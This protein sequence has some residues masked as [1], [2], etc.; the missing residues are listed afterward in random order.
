MST[1]SNSTAGLAGRVAIVTGA[2]RGIGRCHALFLAEHGAKVVVNDYG[3]SREG[4]G[5]DLSPA[6]S[7]VREIQAAGGEAVT[8]ADDVADW[9]GA[10]RLVDTAITAF[11]GLDIL[12][13]NA[14]FV[15]DRTLVNMSEGEWDDVIRVHLKG[16]FCPTRHAAAYWRDRSKAGQQPNAAVINTSSTSGLFGK[17]GQS[18]YGAAKMGL[19][20]FTMITAEELSRYGVRVNAIAPAARTRLTQGLGGAVDE[21]PAAGTFDELDPANVSPMV[22]YLASGDCSI[23]GKVFLV[24]GGQVHLFKPFS[25]VDGIETDGRWT[26]E[27]LAGKAERF[28]DVEFDVGNTFGF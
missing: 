12:V 3:G 26:L 23:T 22:G 18:N 9:E 20:A 19:A 25:I 16:H 7:V 24:F 27:D 17:L 2:G 15:R 14:G 28:A 11:G 5:H 6:E 21:A 4:A 8:N 13:N 1:T 10:G